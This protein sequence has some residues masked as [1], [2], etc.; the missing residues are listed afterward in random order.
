MKYF[1]KISLPVLQAQGLSPAQ[2]L[3]PPAQQLNDD[4]E[5]STENGECHYG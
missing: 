5:R 3:A 1:H 4:P 2:R